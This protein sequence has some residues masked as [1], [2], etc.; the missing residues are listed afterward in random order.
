MEKVAD[1]LIEALRSLL[2]NVNGPTGSARKLYNGIWESVVL[3]AAPVWAKTVERN[4]NRN[5]LKRAQRAAL[6]RLSTAYRTV[7]HAA[8]CVLTGTLP[9]YY[10]V[11]L[12]AE[13]YRF[14]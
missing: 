8:L 12:R 7:S 9:L 6:V 1:A 5:A 13:K 10:T 2:P 14:K 3:Y 11:E 4:K